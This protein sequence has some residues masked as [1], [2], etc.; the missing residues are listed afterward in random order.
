ML[1]KI[2]LLA[3]A[4]AALAAP[5]AAQ[6]VEL[7]DNEGNALPLNS[8]IKATSSNFIVESGF[9]TFLVCKG[10]TLKAN[11]AENGP[12]QVTLNKISTAA[13]E[14]TFN[15]A[16]AFVTKPSLEP[17]LLFGGQGVSSF[18]FKYDI[19]SVNL[20]ECHLEGPLALTYAAETDEFHIPGAKLTGL[21][22]DPAQCLNVGTLSADFTLEEP[23]GA[24]VTI[25]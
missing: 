24:P 10:V 4:V 15:G 9:A 12:G 3:A 19:P 22:T 13:T 5:A 17:V 25:D 14:C 23:E 20:F 7:T 21:T 11:V 8:E 1:R 18:T 16:I 2:I 6:A